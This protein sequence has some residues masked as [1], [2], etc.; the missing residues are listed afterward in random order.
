MPPYFPPA[1]DKCPTFVDDSEWHPIVD[2]AAYLTELAQALEGLGAGDGVL[3]SGMTLLP[4]L[5]LCGRSPQDPEYRPLG[6][7]LG[8]AAA[9][10]ATVR[11]L[12]AGRVLAS[13]IPSAVVG[14][15]RANVGYAAAMR[16]W[17]PPGA[18]AGSVAPLR[19][20]ILI[21][22]SGATLGS[23]HQ[24][25]VS[26]LRE[27]TL[28]AYV[29]GVDL[30]GSRFDGPPHD[31][32]R[33]H[34]DRWGW[35]DA[36]VRLRGP[37]AERVWQ[38][39]TQ[40]WSEAATLP[41]RR[42][43]QR[44]GG[45]PRLVALNPAPAASP[46]PAPPRQPPMQP[47]QQ[48][49]GTAVR[50]LRSVHRR[51]LDSVLPWRAGVEWATLPPTGV[52]EIFDALVTAISAAARYIYVEDQYLRECTGGVAR[53]ELW[54]HLQAAAAR[55]VKV[56]LVG[57]GTRDPEDPGVLLPP[58]NRRVNR[59]IRR[60]LDAL[61]A[62]QAAHVAVWRVEKLTVHAKIV[63]VDD[64]FGCIGSANM[65]SRSMAGVD[66]EV[67]A[68]VETT[69]TVVR[70]LRVRLWAEHLRTPVTDA[71]RLSLQDLDIAL[72]IWDER[73]LAA[74]IPPDVRR[75]MWRAPGV[76]VGFAPVEQMLARVPARRR[77]PR[78]LP[79]V[80]RPPDRAPV[81]QR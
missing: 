63:L 27:G 2:G 67:S 33:L 11:V 43:L 81:G 64:T 1:T 80:R 61:P 36:V 10:G 22:F 19:G 76:P 16:G 6:A 48:G 29:G 5:D 56:I 58:L 40:R 21:D 42:Y 66:Q 25:I 31:R 50:V 34:G 35:H 7:T 75:D 62:Q 3:I 72:G 20:S 38:I 47:S 30:S 45:R 37:A 44:D 60:V 8:C 69:T 18:A 71:L 26:V 51:K 55:G 77:L 4:S 65:F 24:K 79:A 70:D 52:H 73:W 49:R 12:I 54:P 78:L 9:A 15:F 28:T 57:S 32:L 39:Q 46:A 41:P 23:N 68:A 17:L 74:A 13:S 53:H 59:D 14:D